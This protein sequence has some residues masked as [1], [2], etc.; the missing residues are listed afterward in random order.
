MCPTGCGPLYK[1]G[2]DL[3]DTTCP[4]GFGYFDRFG[5]F[6]AGDRV[7]GG[8]ALSRESYAIHCTTCPVH[9]DP[10]NRDAETMSLHHDQNRGFQDYFLPETGIDFEVLK[11]YVARDGASASARPAPF[12]V[13]L[14]VSIY[15]TV[16]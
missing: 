10:R 7:R 1:P 12:N 4:C 13:I 8:Q 16:L 2:A 15:L 14:T 9:A 6:V 3:R 11:I 5:L